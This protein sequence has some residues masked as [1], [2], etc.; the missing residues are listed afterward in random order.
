MFRHFWV[1]VGLVFQKPFILITCAYY[2]MLDQTYI[3]FQFGQNKISG[4][5]TQA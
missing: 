4:L 3:W 5:N 2:Y 1:N